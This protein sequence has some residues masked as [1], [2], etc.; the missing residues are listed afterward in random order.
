MIF[1]ITAIVSTV[2]LIDSP[3]SDRPVDA[4]AAGRI[5]AADRSAD[6]ADRN[7]A[8]DDRSTVDR[9]TATDRTS[10]PSD[11]STAPADQ[12]TPSAGAP[13]V[14]RRNAGRLDRGAGADRIGSTPPNPLSG[15]GDTLTLDS[16][17]KKPEMEKPPTSL[18]R[19]AVQMTG[20]PVLELTPLE[21]RDFGIRPDRD[22]WGMHT[23]G[24]R[25]RTFYLWYGA[26]RK[27]TM[28]TDSLPPSTW[29]APTLSAQA[30]LV[31]TP[32]GAMRSMAIA[33]EKF[34][35][36]ETRLMRSAQSRNERAM[37]FLGY[38]AKL[39]AYLDQI[40]PSLIPI[41][42]H[43]GSPDSSETILLWFVPDPETIARL[44]ERVRSEIM[45]EL[46]AAED[47][48]KGRTT[49]QQF[50]SAAPAPMFD[51]LQSADGS[52]R[53][54]LLSTTFPAYDR[55]I[56]VTSQKCTLNLKL[57]EP[58]TLRVELFDIQ[59]RR[60]DQ[61]VG[62]R[63]FAAGNQ[64]LEFDVASDS[65]GMYRVVLTSEREERVVHRLWVMEWGGTMPDGLIIGTPRDPERK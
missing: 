23:R 65:E 3:W 6:S 14:S 46:K 16:I 13:F 34:A 33:D 1:G 48:E 22:G 43:V 39:R 49:E 56:P 27:F 29:N 63:T 55:N 44:P 7:H 2:V 11:R 59:G 17:H 15:T 53:T 62:A 64:S 10:A 58:R 42:L 26:Q 45:M 51:L 54:S 61:L 25:D 5:V 32:D 19:G 30:V 24:S 8:P 50:L 36:E 21:L 40:T 20:I 31:T 37:A 35:P 41:A 52:I 4:P 18:N 28:S 38:R 9:L 57:A 47:Y 12:R 60:V